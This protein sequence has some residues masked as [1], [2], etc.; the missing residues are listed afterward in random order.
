MMLVT[1]M[2]ILRMAL[3]SQ[4]CILLILFIIETELIYFVAGYTKEECSERGGT[5]SGTCASGFGVCCISEYF[6]CMDLAIIDM[7]W[8][9]IFISFS[10]TIHCGDT[11][12][13]VCKIDKWITH[14]IL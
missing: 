5:E 13:E 8:S 1:V 11:T 10:D 2:I 7:N 4:F 12:K 6:F 9:F 3:V 14:H